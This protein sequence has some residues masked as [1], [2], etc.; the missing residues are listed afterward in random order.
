M[1]Y[2]AASGRPG[3]DTAFDNGQMKVGR[4][5]A[6]KVLNAS[7]FVLGVGATLHSPSTGAV[8]DPLDRA[9]LAEL[10]DVVVDATDAFDDYNY[11][12]ALE[13]T[14][15]FFWMFSDDY[16]ELVKERAYRSTADA[17]A[18]SAHATLATAL[19][20]LHRLF[21]PVLPFVTEEVWSWWQDG[22]VHRAA[23]PTAD[24]VRAVAGDGRPELLDAVAWSSQRFARPSP[25]PRSRCAPR[26]CAPTC[27]APPSGWRCS[28][29]PVRTWRPP[30]GSLS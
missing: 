16:V 8:T 1:R 21:A 25:T 12:R 17:G 5:L 20:V 14:E 18:R 3:T 30:V 24:D 11:S 4:R 13:V 23:W 27:A 6:I 7:K 22:S 9:L 29:A 10:A 15:T 2:W 19:S 28:P 26:S